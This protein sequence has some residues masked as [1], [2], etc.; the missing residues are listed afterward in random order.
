MNEL[1]KTNAMRILEK[2]KIKYSILKYKVDEN[3]LDAIHI[4]TNS[5]LSLELVYKTIV[6]I[7]EKN[8]IFIFCL[9]AEFNVSLKKAKSIT[10]SKKIS[11]L[12]LKNLKKTTGYIRGGC[13]PI[14][15]IK[16]YPTYISEFAQIEDY[17]Y[18]SGGQRGLQL[19]I[20][21]FDLS[22][23]INAKFRDFI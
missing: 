5:K 11:L 23:C 20:N 19:K 2:N 13:S 7:N 16:E 22:K 8:E 18:I 6:L 12:E 9:P 1:K 15:M 3:N 4:A 10:N 17:I 14:G 21:P